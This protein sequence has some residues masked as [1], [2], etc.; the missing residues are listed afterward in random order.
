MNFLVTMRALLTRM[1]QWVRD[2]VEPPPSAYP[3]IDAGTLVRLDDVNFP[4]VQGV[5]R[6]S[7]AHEAYRADYGPRWLEGIIDHQP[8]KLG[9]TFPTLVPQVDMF[10]NDL[11]GLES[12]EIL[13]P[14]ATYT[15]WNLRIDYPGGPEEMTD[16]L[17]TYVPLPMTEAE[18]EAAGDSRPSLESLYSS[19]QEYLQL[20][21]RAARSLV[22]RGTLLEEDVPQVVRRAS[23]HWDWVMG[24]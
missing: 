19:K 3:R 17:G 24:H 18:R 14:L 23:D 5:T 21:E 9:P 12:V 7:V 16:F 2:D 10:G 6:P 22:E 8:P 1:V 11:G 4:T 13:A 20:A 15:P